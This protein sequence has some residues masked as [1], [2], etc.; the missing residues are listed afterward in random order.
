MRA[1]WGLFFGLMLIAPA[2]AQE[3]TRDLA[4]SVLEDS[5]CQRDL[6]GQGDVQ[7]SSEG[8]GERK[9]RST[10]GPSLF[11]GTGFGSGISMIFLW[12]F[13]TIFVVVLIAIL[14]RSKRS[15]APRKLSRGPLILQAATSPAPAPL[16]E[17]A[18][19]AE[20]GDFAGAVHAALLH[21]FA[22]CAQRMG[23]LPQ[24]ATGRQVLRL[25]KRHTLPTDHLGELVMTVERVHFGGQVADR[26][27]YENSNRHLQEWEAACQIQS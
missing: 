9:Q 1:L 10:R 14:V 17:H 16:P 11:S 3:V 2:T 19:L 25:A 20:D 6:P 26:E 4:R 24:H 13:V 27:L 23:A 12:F 8:G 15:V 18:R 21:A 7:G 22:S 5:N